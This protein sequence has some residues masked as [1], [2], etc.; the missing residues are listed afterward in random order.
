MVTI[1]AL[2]GVLAVLFA[3][4]VL[5]TREQGLLAEVSPDDA[6]VPLPSEPLTPEDVH[7][8]RFSLAL[9]GYRMAEVDEVLDRLASELADRDRR[10]GLLEAAASTAPAAVPEAPVREAVM[11]DLPVVAA[12][13]PVSLAGTEPPSEPFPEPIV[14]PAP[15]P[16]PA[17]DP[18]PTPEPD[19]PAPP[20]EPTPAP[21]PD[22]APTPTPEPDPPA[23]P[24]EPTPVVPAPVASPTAWS[25][26]S[27]FPAF[28]VIDAPDVDAPVQDPLPPA[29]LPSE[30]VAEERAEERTEADRQ[31]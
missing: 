5:S 3:A 1:L 8:L 2:L 13:V 30:L 9:R 18:T 11:E 22:P 19:P 23:P 24:F 29:D 4:A 17:P 16:T 6:D 21:A 12:P 28:P 7:G 31:Q 20:F 14:P 10:I 26:P 15:V 25:S 27:S